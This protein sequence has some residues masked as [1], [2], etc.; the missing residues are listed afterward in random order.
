[1]G[2]GCGYSSYTQSYTCH[3]II[4]ESKALT[5]FLIA[6]QSFD[7]VAEIRMSLYLCIF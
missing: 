1:L 4:F 7:G 5:K 6:S 2:T 3:I